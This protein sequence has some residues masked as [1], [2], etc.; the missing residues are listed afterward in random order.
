M[1]FLFLLAVTGMAAVWDIRT[2]KVPNIL[3]AAGLGIACWFRMMESGRAGFWQFLGGGI[4]PL[5]LLAALFYFRMLGAGDIKLFCVIG[6]FLGTEGLLSCMAVSFLT[7]A[8][9]SLILLFKRRILKK[10]L[11]YFF[12]YIGEFIRTG[13]WVPYRD[14]MDREAGFCFTVPIFF[15][16]LLVLSGNVS[17]FRI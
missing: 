15:S 9:L 7:G 1:K 17:E 3:I 12:A 8:V 5:L 6:G 16:V 2:G 13:I 4:L 10:R 14:G 11:Q